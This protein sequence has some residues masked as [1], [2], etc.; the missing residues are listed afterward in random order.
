MLLLLLLLLLQKHSFTELL[1]FLSFFDWWWIPPHSI[2]APPPLLVSCQHLHEM[3]SHVELWARGWSACARALALHTHTHIYTH[4]HP[5]RETK[6]EFEEISMYANWASEQ[7]EDEREYAR[8]EMEQEGKRL[9]EWRTKVDG[10]RLDARKGPVWMMK[11][12]LSSLDLFRFKF[13]PNTSCTDAALA[14]LR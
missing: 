13:P 10:E 8:K 7:E 1:G 2:H 9:R 14:R 4:P 12:A 5:L 3:V 6:K 11:L